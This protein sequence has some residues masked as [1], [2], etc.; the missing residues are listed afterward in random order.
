MRHFSVAQ[1]AKYCGVNSDS[2]IGW[3]KRGQIKAL[4]APENGEY[5][6]SIEN[7]LKVKVNSVS[8]NRSFDQ[9]KILILDTDSFNITSIYSIFSHHGLSAVS[10]RDGHE[11]IELL[12]DIGPAILI[13]NLSM[14][15][16]S[17]LGFLE[18]MNNLGL[19]ENL[20]VIIVSNANESELI[21]AVDV[22][23]DFYLQKPFSESDLDKIIKKLTCDTMK[24]LAA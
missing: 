9:S 22:G 17:G 21:S 4:K 12:N 23:G 6:I 8:R 2:I 3:I 5:Q 14:S 1:F 15:G 11:V 18:I 16:V 7:L 19:R 24:K 10:A 20:W 13:L